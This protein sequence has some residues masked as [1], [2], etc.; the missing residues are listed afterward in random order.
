M[1]EKVKEF[2][3]SFINNEENGSIEFT[4][5]NTAKLQKYIEQ[6]F[7]I[8]SI[9]SSIKNKEKNIYKSGL[10]AILYLAQ[11][12]F[13]IE[14]EW[15]CIG[16]YDSPGYDMSDYA[17]ACILPTGELYFDSWSQERC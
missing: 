2:I 5:E 3:W 8:N 14:F 16:T 15:D 13:N 7:E 10:G 6:G 1:K 17:W 12:E 9:V 4:K 11:L